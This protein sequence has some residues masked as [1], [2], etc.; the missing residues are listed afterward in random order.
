MLEIHGGENTAF[1]V[2]FRESSTRNLSVQDR[3]KNKANEK[4]Y[5]NTNA[6]RQQIG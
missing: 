1:V 6:Q 4:V 2:V 5:R 3:K